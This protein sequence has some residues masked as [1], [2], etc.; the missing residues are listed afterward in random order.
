MA[1]HFP[2]QSRTGRTTFAHGGADNTAPFNGNF[3]TAIVSGTGAWTSTEATDTMMFSGSSGIAGPW[4]SAEVADFFAASGYLPIVGTFNRTEATDTAEF[5]GITAPNGT[6]VVSEKPDIFYA[7]K[8]R[9]KRLEIVNVK[10]DAG[11]S[12]RYTT[13][14][15]DLMLVMM[16]SCSTVGTTHLPNLV[17]WPTVTVEHH[18]E[19]KFVPEMTTVIGP[20]QGDH[21]LSGQILYAFAPEPIN[22]EVVSFDTYNI[23]DSPGGSTSVTHIFAIKGLNG[24]FGYPFTDANPF[25]RGS[26][27]GGLFPAVSGAETVQS[28]SPVITGPPV[29]PTTSA[30][31]F[32]GGTSSHVTLSGGNLIVTSTGTSEAFAEVAQTAS[33][34]SFTYI[35]VKFNNI[36]NGNSDY[37]A[38]LAWLGA[39][40]SDLNG[41]GTNGLMIK[42]NG[43]VWS[44]GV[45]Y[46]TITP[47][48]NNDVIGIAVNTEARLAYVRN[49]TQGDSFTGHPEYSGYGSKAAGGIPISGGYFG[50][51][52][53]GVVRGGVSD[54]KD[55][56]LIGYQ[57]VN[58]MPIAFPG[59]ANSSGQ[60]TW[61]FGATSM[62]GS[63]PTGFQAGYGVVTDLAP[64]RAT[65][66]HV[67]VGMAWDSNYDSADP[68]MLTAPPNYTAL[69]NTQVGGSQTTMNMISYAQVRGQNILETDND[70]QAAGA[71]N[72]WAMQF[73]TLV[74]GEPNPGDW[75]STEA[76]DHFVGV[77]Y[78]IPGTH[79]ILAGTEAKDAMAFVG[80]IPALGEW[81]VTEAKDI[82]SMFIKIPIQ[83]VF[84]KTEAPDT[85][86]STGIGL[87][88][89]GEW[90]STESLDIFAATG[91]VP[92]SGPFDTFEAPDRFL[93][94]GAGVTRVRRRRSFFVS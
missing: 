63:P 10:P 53:H 28:F 31:T 17:D 22:D 84:V 61:N 46:A 9:L 26:G 65:Y 34:P 89:D 55:N 38:G 5:T 35:E 52:P 69:G 47:P 91:T 29:S 24:N 83:G 39:D 49:V 88:E 62:A 40:T 20:I 71:A 82:F 94:L 8:P 59:S 72:K 27:V 21:W 7:N 42:A 81:A 60:Q 18:P 50:G 1:D 13:T 67:V 2:I 25:C 70:F 93:A 54:P 57:P 16:F 32:A 77:G 36:Q 11:G 58:L 48:V 86:H 85:F 64:A 87:G 23:N 33:I 44:G 80:N 41:D 3:L 37:G 4:V 73:D 78:L 68:T 75:S 30:V 12:F 56:G 90:H 14:E 43:S 45:Q 15:R 19:I 92:I 66:P 79:G 76:A 51:P 6:F 74:V